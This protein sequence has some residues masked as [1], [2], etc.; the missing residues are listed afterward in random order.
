MRLLH[1]GLRKEEGVYRE[2]YIEIRSRKASDEATNYAA[3]LI[4]VVNM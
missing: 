1:T 3:T 2:G 4:K